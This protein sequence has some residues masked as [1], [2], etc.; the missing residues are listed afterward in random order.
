M[1]KGWYILLY[2][3]VSWEESPFVR[4]IGGTCPPDIFRDHL[5]HL[6]MAGRF[7][8]ID[9]GLRRL[10]DGGPDEPLFSI[11]FDDGLAGV[12]K[13]AVPLVEQLGITG[14]YSVCSRFFNRQE[15]FWRFKLS[16]LSYVD[17]MRFLRS[18]LRAYG[19]KSSQSIKVFCLERFSSEV[20]GAIDDVFE[21]FTSD[22]ERRDAFRLFEAPA[23]LRDLKARGWTIANH[24]AAH[25][26]VGFDGCADMF[27]PQFTECEGAYQK[28]LGEASMFWVLPFGHASD[29]PPDT[30]RRCGGDRYLVLVGDKINEA[31]G[32]A[33]PILYRIGVPIC[34]GSELIRF[35]SR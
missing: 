17:G 28:L 5:R 19:Y 34:T 13:Y 33:Q 10:N 15:F 25:Y 35:L 18:R 7:V 21:R 8:S 30:F 16:Y 24:T 1:R 23:G 26:P 31:D 9:E 14:G 11:W 29:A 3:D 12:A 6:R 2:H 32:G 20:L 22:L 4:G 27:E